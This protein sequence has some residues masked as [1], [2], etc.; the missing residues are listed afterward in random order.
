MEKEKSGVGLGKKLKAS[1]FSEK[2]KVRKVLEFQNCR[3]SREKRETR[4]RGR[5]SIL[6]VLK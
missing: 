5:D 4:D 6:F 1:E 3:E 2:N